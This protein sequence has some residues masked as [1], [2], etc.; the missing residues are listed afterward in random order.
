MKHAARILVCTVIVFVFYSFGMHMSDIKSA[1]VQNQIEGNGPLTLTVIL[2]KK[3]L[4]GEVS[5]EIIKETIWSM[6]D[7]WNTYKD[8]QLVQQDDEQIVF[9]KNFNDISP[10]SKANGY[11]GITSDGTLTIFEG[12]PHQSSKIIQ[13][14]FQIDLGKLESSD[15][16]LLKKGIPVQSK[17]HFK[18]VIE[19]FK[20]YSFTLKK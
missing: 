12:K 19:T 7:F 2:E 4:D 3:Y 11:F 8:W 17:D 6:E 20:P 16:K 10:L 9:T 5:E 13:T 14:F 1:N 15:H 18:K